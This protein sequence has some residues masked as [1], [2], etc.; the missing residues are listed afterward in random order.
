[1]ILYCIYNYLQMS[2]FVLGAFGLVGSVIKF[3]FWTVVTVGTVGGAF[4]YMTKP[5]NKSFDKYMNSQIRQNTPP[6]VSLVPNKVVNVAK[7]AITTTV[8]KDYVVVKVAEVT[9]VGDN[10]TNYYIGVVQ[11]WFAM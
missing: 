2:D 9:V 8:V 5:D 10:K 11:N 6:I 7:S 3:G 4:L 1:M